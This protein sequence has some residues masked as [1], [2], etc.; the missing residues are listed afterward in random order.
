MH[1]AH[2]ATDIQADRPAQFL[3]AS[4]FPWNVRGRRSPMHWKRPRQLPSSARAGASN[5]NPDQSQ[6][7]PGTAPGTPRQTFGQLPWTALE[8]MSHGRGPECSLERNDAKTPHPAPEMPTVSQW[9]RYAPRACKILLSWEETS[10]RPVIPG[11]NI[12]EKKSSPR[13]A[14]SRNWD[15]R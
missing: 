12:I 7:P 6:M 13:C 8:G 3:V 4:I 11:G 14:E 9:H 2:A 5:H 1:H 10:E 15:A